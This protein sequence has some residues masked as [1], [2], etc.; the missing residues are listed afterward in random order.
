MPFPEELQPYLKA[1]S[2]Q[3][4]VVLRNAKFADELRRS[5]IETVKQF[6]KASEFHDS[7]TGGHIER[8]SRYSA[9]IYRALG[10]DDKDCHII[11]LASMLHDVGKISIPDAILK[12]PGKLT[13][14]EFEVMKRHT[15][16]GYGML[17]GAES[18]FLTMGAVIA[19]GH[20][21]K[22]NGTGYPRGQKGEEIPLV[23]RVV[24]LADVFDALCSRRCYK[25]SWPIESVLDE[26]KAGSGSHFDPTLV[27]LFF[28]N[29]D[30]V[31]EIR[32]SFPLDMGPAA[33]ILQ[34]AS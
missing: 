3:F 16:N 22:W 13:P 1:L 17:I 26:I 2:S 21:E 5:R 28:K 34:K 30:K 33:D 29:L 6:V 4:G 19:R 14:E 18:P 32:D 24:A 27:E 9:L 31:F 15:E 7:D 10:F 12:K 11:E 25:E 20:H 8:M 23:A